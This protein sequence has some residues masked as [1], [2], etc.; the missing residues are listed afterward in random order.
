MQSIFVCHHEFV[1]ILIFAS[2][3]DI[4][5]VDMNLCVI[6]Y[7]DIIYS[8]KHNECSFLIYFISLWLHA[9]SGMTLCVCAIIVVSNNDHAI[10][11]AKGKLSTVCNAS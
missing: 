8:E 4:W 7:F 11:M 6:R 9:K 5:K 1:I 2:S 3:L 10:S